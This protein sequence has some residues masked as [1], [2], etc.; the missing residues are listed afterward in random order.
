VDTGPFIASILTASGI[1]VIN[2]LDNTHFAENPYDSEN[3]TM[4]PKTEIYT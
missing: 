3:I 1:N 4:R 2:V